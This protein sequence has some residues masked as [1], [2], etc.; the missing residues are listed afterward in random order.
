M[1]GLTVKYDVIEVSPD[2]SREVQSYVS[3]ERP[4]VLWLNGEKVASPVMTPDDVEA[5]AIGHLVCEGR[6]T[7]LSQVKKVIPNL[8]SIEVE[9]SLSRADKVLTGASCCDVPLAAGPVVDRDVILYAAGSMN[10]FAVQWRKTGATYCS[11]LFDEYGG[12]ISYAEDIGRHTSIDKTIG[13]AFMGGR[14]LSRS[15]LVTSGTTPA[16]IVSKAYRAG[17]PMIVSNTAPLTSA[18]E[19]AR[20]RN[21]T[22]ICFARPPRMYV[23]SVP[24][25]IGGINVG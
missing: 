13:K 20:K 1:D 22:L 19:T 17:I 5:F 8:P 14:D 23:F 12:I 25:R 2:S 7:S 6:I 10:D 24:S 11:M 9:A 4:A 16:A 15:F 18:I 21:M 3:L